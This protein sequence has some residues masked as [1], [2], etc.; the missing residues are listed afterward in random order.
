MRYVRISQDE[1]ASV[2]KLYEG[3][4][5]YACHGL[6]F[7][8]GAS[9]MDG[10]AKDLE[11]KENFLEA[12]RHAVVNRGWAEEMEFSPNQVRVRGSI[13]VAL[14]SE[15]E[16]CHRMRGILTRMFEMQTRGRVKMTEAECESTGS[17]RCVFRM[18]VS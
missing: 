14:G 13:E 6:F 3:V 8:E 16:T 7:R 18:E 11:R 15:A 17:P 12:A 2:R 5:A 1:F 4:M 9:I 10:I